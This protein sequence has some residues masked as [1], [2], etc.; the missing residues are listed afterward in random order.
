MTAR[1]VVGWPDEFARSREDLHAALV[2]SALLGITPRRLLELAVQHGTASVVLAE[3]RE[4]RA[5][6]EGDREHA[7]TLD[8]VGIAAAA[9][10]CGA[11]L[12]AWGS[13]QYPEQLRHL[14]DPPAILYVIGR[15]LPDRPSAVAVVGSRSCSELGRELGREIGRA[16]GSAGVTVV[17]G[18][19]RGIDAAAHEGA[20]DG[21]GTTLA[22]LGCGVDVEY[23]RR[24]R[25]L[26]DRIRAHGTLVSELAPGTPP[27]PRNFPARNRIVAGLC[28]AT[29]VVEGAG[30]SGSMITAEHAMEFGR[31]VYA[32]PGPVTSALSEVPL[33]LLRDGATLI[34]GPEDLLEDLGLERGQAPLPGLGELTPDERRALERLTGPTLPDRLAAELGTGVAETVGV[35]MRLELR[36]LVRV[37]GGR[38]EPTLGGARAVSG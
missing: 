11:R 15:A 3:I 19:A 7:R 22:V 14:P 34:R 27:V 1:P 28:G 13:P 31:D 37:A 32:V 5:G 36:G 12:V 33:R 38:Y 10:G 18:A 16:L 20:L 25:A 35:L 24:G 23:P 21:G 4:G 29:V 26:L 30:G 17:S 9:H 2:L 6:S 8:P